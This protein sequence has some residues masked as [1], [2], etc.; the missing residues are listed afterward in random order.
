M[1][2]DPSEAA[3]CCACAQMWVNLLLLFFGCYTVLL[4]GAWSFWFKN[5]AQ[6][7]VVNEWQNA[8][9]TSVVWFHVALYLTSIGVTIFLRFQRSTLA[10][11]PSKGRWS[12][13]STR[14]FRSRFEVGDLELTES[15]PKSNGKRKKSKSRPRTPARTEESD[16]DERERVESAELD[17]QVEAMVAAAAGPPPKE[18]QPADPKP[19]AEAEAALRAEVNIELD[20]EKPSQ[21]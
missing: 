2:F 1:Y 21:V 15:Q 3:T 13:V 11:M 6:A 17:K 5:N 9:L 8:V 14:D 12:A 19:A 7:Q 4:I 10:I 20:A 18:D 16:A